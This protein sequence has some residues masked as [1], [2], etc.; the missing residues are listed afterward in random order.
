MDPVRLAA[1]LS[2]P[3]A[4]VR[5]ALPAVSIGYLLLL[6]GGSPGLVAGL[7]A[8]LVGGVALVGARAPVSVA[9]AQVLVLVVAEF[10]AQDALPMFKLMASIAVLDV[11]VRRPLRSAL[12]CAG[13]LA[14]VIVVAFVAASGQ[15]DVLGLAHRATFTV[16]APLL[17]GLWLRSAADAIEQS[18]SAARA[19][20]EGRQEGVRAAR[21]AERTGIAREVHDLVAH[22]V[23]S[24]ALRTAVA[25]EVLTV[26]DPRVR[27]VLDE[28]HDA[29]IVA[30]G[31][32]R[33][34]VSVLRDPAAV[35]GSEP[36]G[37]GL[38]DPADLP[39]LVQT[40]V[41]RSNA[42]GVRTTA[43]T[44][45][46]TGRL[47]AVRGLTVLRVVQEGLTNVAKHAGPGAA[48][49]VHVDVDDH[50]VRV[51]VRDTP[52]STG[53][54]GRVHTAAFEPSGLGLA[55]LRERAA[56]LG[57][58]LV[59]G[60]AGAGWETAVTLPLELTAP[61]SESRE[62]LVADGTAP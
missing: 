13:L 27:A 55:G 41:D 62:T 12:T 28:V 42:S 10:A 21:L 14:G 26:P 9:V 54:A 48:A 23:A 60:P 47:D 5:L 51:R 35:Q 22:H 46:D 7:L 20:E 4:A 2:R 30:L 17:L 49:D 1:L 25:R 24:I 43:H 19:A 8:V 37:P 6:T 57:G 44:G 38:V 33:Q 34:L 31:D 40:A 11:A 39:A 45:P 56:L 15:L 53:R 32:L 16:V 61:Q 3:W 52:S 59:A 36:L 50:V 18:R 58:S 29:A